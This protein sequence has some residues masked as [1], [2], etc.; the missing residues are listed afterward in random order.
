MA[1]AIITNWNG[2]PR[3]WKI[4]LWKI[5]ILIKPALF[6]RV[7]SCYRNSWVFQCNLLHYLTKEVVYRDK[8]AFLTL[9]FRIKHL[10]SSLSICYCFLV[11]TFIRWSFRITPEL[12]K[13]FKTCPVR[14]VRRNEQK[15]SVS[16]FLYSSMGILSCLRLPAAFYYAGNPKT[17][18][19]D[20]CGFTA[21]GAGWFL[22]Q[23]F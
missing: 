11:L 18:A 4:D 8:R 15:F 22:N 17:G 7:F 10:L 9:F 13:A 21:R 19:G 14:Q 16:I 12:N 6:G 2:F 20:G 23:N 3:L 5:N 1:N